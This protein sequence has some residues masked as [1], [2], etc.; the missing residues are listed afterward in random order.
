MCV[1]VCV[2][3]SLSLSLFFRLHGSLKVENRPFKIQIPSKLVFEHS[4]R[5]FKAFEFPISCF[6]CI[7]FYEKAC[8]AAFEEKIRAVW[9]LQAE[10]WAD[11]KNPGIGQLIICLSFGQFQAYSSSPVVEADLTD[12]RQ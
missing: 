12:G 3:L 8:E 6:L 9:V 2:S 10:V 11:Q 4:E 1:C 5:R 7:I